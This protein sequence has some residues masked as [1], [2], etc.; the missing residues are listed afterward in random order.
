MSSG[1]IGAFDRFC[2][3]Q[4]SVNA[5]SVGSSTSAEQTF[6]LP[7][8]ATSDIVVQVTKPSLTAGLSIGN[9]RVTAAN[10][11]GITF[12]NSTASPIDPAAE[13][14]TFIVMRPEKVPGGP[15]ALSGGAVIFN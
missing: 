9:S 7:G 8:I 1:G 12:V 6:T 4:L 14:Y 13:T 15:D 3:T 5:A 2:I 11:V 10:T